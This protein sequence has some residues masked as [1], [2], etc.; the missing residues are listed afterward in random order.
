MRI[1]GE[2]SVVSKEQINKL[3]EKKPTM[4]IEEANNECI[5]FYGCKETS[6]VGARINGFVHCNY[7]NKENKEEKI[8]FPIT[9]VI[10][11]GMIYFLKLTNEERLNYLINNSPKNVSVSDLKET[12]VEFEEYLKGILREKGLPEAVITKLKLEE[13]METAIAF[14]NN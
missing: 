1:L 12:D 9:K 10:E 4:T 3:V 14:L 2:K 6:S 13:I 5:E 8:F 11:A 7:K